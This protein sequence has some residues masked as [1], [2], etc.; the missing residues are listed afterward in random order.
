MQLFHSIYPPWATITI[1][2]SPLLF[3][4]FTADLEEYLE[5]ALAYMYADDTTT[6]AAGTEEEGRLA[7]EKDTVNL[8]HYISAN[9]LGEYQLSEKRFVA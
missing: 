9:L 6:L 1:C 7:L 4:K 5:V 3:L 8:L 2:L